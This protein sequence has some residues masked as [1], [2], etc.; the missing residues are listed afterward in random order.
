MKTDELIAMLATG[1]VPV[2]PNAAARRFAMA[3]GWGLFG[4]T[5][6]MALIFGVRADM[7]Q[8]VLLPMFWVKL[9]VPATAALAALR[10]SKRLACPGMQPGHAPILL[11]TL[12]L[13]AWVGAAASLLGSAPAERMELVLGY[14]WKTCTLSIALLSLPLLSTLIWALKGLA[15]VRPVLAGGSAGLLAGAASAT[16]YALHCPEMAVPFLG[17]W[18][19]LGIM[20]PTALGAMLGPKLLR[21]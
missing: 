4:V 11:G 2:E 13:V 1:A 18:Y 17:I 10:L 15:P 9:L 3:L 21:W 19:V 20:T 16:I 14:T 5:L 7:A 6:L 8:A 12:L